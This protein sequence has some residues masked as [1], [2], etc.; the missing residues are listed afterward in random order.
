MT[1]PT[2]T[3]DTSERENATHLTG[4]CA[5]MAA[6]IL[7]LIGLLVAFG[8][9]PWRHSTHWLPLLFVAMS[10][11]PFVIVG[12]F[13]LRTSPRWALG[14]ASALGWVTMFAILLLTVV[15][16]IGV[17]LILGG[18]GFLIP[19][20][21]AL[22]DA[23]HYVHRAMPSGGNALMVV[24]FLVSIVL[25]KQAHDARR[26]TR[27]SPANNDWGKGSAAIWA[28]AIVG[29]FV[30]TQAHHAE[31]KSRFDDATQ[32]QNAYDTLVVKVRHVLRKAQSCLLDYHQ[33]HPL[34]FPVSLD[35]IGPGGTGCFDPSAA[36]DVLA[37]TRIRYAALPD[38]SARRTSF[39]MV[40]EPTVKG[41]PFGNLYYAS[42]D[43]T[44]YWAR[45]L[46]RDDSLRNDRRVPEPPLP[47]T[48]AVEP[49]LVDSPIRELTGFRDCLARQ[50]PL[51][52]YMGSQM[53]SSN[54]FT[55]ADG[56]K[57]MS[58]GEG[59]TS[60]VGGEYILVYHPRREIPKTTAVKAI[61]IEARPARYGF[62]GVRSYLIDEAGGVHWTAYN[63]AATL[64]DSVLVKCE[65]EKFGICPPS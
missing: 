11:T 45:L 30:F 20:L 23:G 8:Q 61:S 14:A 34:G 1:T 27:A 56:S 28:Y 53:C 58:V 51:P 38:S 7:I 5:L 60:T 40:V 63:R 19:G 10:A 33:S 2:S 32:Q 37:G 24:L 18:P 43:G 42:S 65:W 44:L 3:S 57:A 9:P 25:V 39:W 41:A 54:I 62:D 49:H 26:H 52:A 4:T 64:G 31:Q 16:L 17:F 46:G 50:E 47:M 13:L 22:T 12:V 6:G 35:S 55:T 48:N 36:R 15:A 29:T 59:I 21:P